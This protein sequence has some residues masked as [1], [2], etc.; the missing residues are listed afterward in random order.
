MREDVELITKKNGIS[1]VQCK[2]CRNLIGEVL[3]ANLM[4]RNGT[5]AERTITQAVDGFVANH[6]PACPGKPL[7]VPPGKRRFIPL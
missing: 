2:K 5:D 3:T 4:I 7:A 1:V 6:A